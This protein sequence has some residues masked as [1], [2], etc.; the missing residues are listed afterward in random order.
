MD[1]MMILEA[2]VAIILFMVACFFIV[3]IAVIICIG[4]LQVIELAI[5]G[6]K[7]WLKFHIF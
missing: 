2:V 5:D 6:I 3:L 7:D 1:I 4:I